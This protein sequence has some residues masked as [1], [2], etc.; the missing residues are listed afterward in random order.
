MQETKIKDNLKTPFLKYI[1]S[2]EKF[3]R[4]IIIIILLLIL[5][6]FIAFIGGQI[7]R[8][9]YSDFTNDMIY[10]GIINS[11]SDDDFNGDYRGFYK[12]FREASG[13]VYEEYSSYKPKPNYYGKYININNNSIRETYQYCSDLDKDSLIV[14]IYGGGVG[15]GR[16]TRDNAT[17][18][19]YISYY[20]C[21]NNLS[22]YVYNYGSFGGVSNQDLIR[23][24]SELKKG[25]IPDIAVFYYGANDAFS[26]SYNGFA[27]HTTSVKDRESEFDSRKKLN[28]LNYAHNSNIANVYR[29]LSELFFKNKPKNYRNL[30][31]MDDD[32]KEEVINII[33]NNSKIIKSME[34]EFAFKSYF[35]IPVSVFHKNKLSDFELK[36]NNSVRN[37]LGQDYIEISNKLKTTDMIDLTFIYENVDENIFIDEMHPSEKGNKIIGE[38]IGKEIAG[39]IKK[40]NF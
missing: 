38:H 7:Y 16:W 14:H 34:D 8:K 23:F 17:I 33:I 37:V 1:L 18:P 21:E 35:F 27:G 39:N 2:I 22:A 19:A 25:N 32:L 9:Y 28:V 3:L 6:E 29:V 15:L 40:R 10:Q 4:I 36:L 31:K 5:L 26:A 12:E 13:I 30:E 24:Q 20:L 11:Y